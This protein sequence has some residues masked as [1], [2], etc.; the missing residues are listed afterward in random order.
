MASISAGHVIELAKDLKRK[1]PTGRDILSHIKSIF[2]WALHEHDQIHG[3][4]YGLKDN[5]A[6]AVNPRRVFGK[7]KPRERTLDETS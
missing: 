3:N 4:R 6:T 7:K 1:S 5:P 2:G